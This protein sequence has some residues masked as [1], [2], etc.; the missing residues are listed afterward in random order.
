LARVN[1]ARLVG[2]ITKHTGRGTDYAQRKAQTWI[3]VAR[4]GVTLYGD[5][6]AVAFDDLADEIATEILLLKTLGAELARHEAAREEAYLV[7]DQHQIARTLPGVGLMGGPILVAAMG[8]PGRFPRAAS[9]RRFT[10][11]T[12]K[13]SETGESDAKGQAMSKS[14]ANWLR[15]QLV[16]SA[17]TARQIDPELA[18]VYYVQMVERGAHHNKALCVVAAHLA[19]RA[20]VTLSRQEPYVLRDLDGT[21]ITVAEGKEIVSTK[22]KVSEDV[23]R[24]R[25]TKKK[26][27][28]APQGVL[29]AQSHSR[30][31]DKRGDLPLT[32]ASPPTPRSSRRTLATT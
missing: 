21:P 25:R 7:V 22:F 12:P 18:R 3:A 27:G 4:A 6:P 2:L 17:N 30:G 31:V 15:A 9:F 28:K 24:R 23:R 11:L 26:A 5:D 29:V 14:G 16:R 8:R 13:A 1:E 32:P 20:W 19:D 10:G